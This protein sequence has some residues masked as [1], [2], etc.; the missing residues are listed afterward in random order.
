MIFI[1]HRGNIEGPNPEKENMPEYIISASNAGFD[2]EV[3]VWNIDGAWLLG[4]DK[5]QYPVEESFLESPGFWCH[6][7]NI[8][9]LREMISNDKINCFWHEED[10]FTLTSFGNIWTYPGKKVTKKSVIV[11]TSLDVPKECRG[12]FGICSDWVN[13]QKLD[14]QND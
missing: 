6:A 7:K 1:S 5:P 10:D 4:H 14:L 9:A 12:A 13:L 3:D 2:V 11:L 8:D